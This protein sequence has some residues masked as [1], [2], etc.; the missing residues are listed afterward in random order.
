MI[1]GVAAE[2]KVVDMCAVMADGAQQPRHLWR[3]ALI[4]QESHAVSR[5]GGS[6]S[7]TAR[8]A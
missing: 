3:Q 4:N 1:V 6:R 5:T 2:A 7:S 8:A